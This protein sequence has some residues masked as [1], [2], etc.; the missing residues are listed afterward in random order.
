MACG[1]AESATPSELAAPAPVTAVLD[2]GF[3]A[4]SDFVEAAAKAAAFTP[5]ESLRTRRNGWRGGG[6]T[7]V[8]D[9]GEMG[10]FTFSTD[11][12]ERPSMRKMDGADAANAEQLT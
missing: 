11:L 5:A 1:P 4:G 8:L 12:C 6:R 7:D 10:L 3:T 2:G 9:D